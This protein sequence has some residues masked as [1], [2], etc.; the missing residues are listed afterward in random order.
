LA[1][2]EHYRRPEVPKTLEGLNDCFRGVLGHQKNNVYYSRHYKQLSQISE[3][4]C[5][6]QKRVLADLRDIIAEVFLN[7][8]QSGLMT[9]ELPCQS[10]YLT[11]TILS[12]CAY[13]TVLNDV[14]LLACVWSL[15]YPTLT[16]AGKLL[17]HCKIENLLGEQ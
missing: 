13:G 1:H 8:R 3:K 12:I 2:H 5:Q 11:Q 6:I 7:L 17:Y 14:N 16:E 10:E 4:I 9:V 15:I